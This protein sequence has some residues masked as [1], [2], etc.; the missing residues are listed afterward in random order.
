MSE[1]EI[2]Y[3][4]P[5]GKKNHYRAGMSKNGKAFI[6]KDRV[7][8]DYETLFKDSCRIYK[9]RNIKVP[10][11]LYLAIF[12]DNKR[13]DIDNVVTSVLDNLQAV[14]AI[15][16]DN[17]CKKIV[18]EKRPAKGIPRVQFAIEAEYKQAELF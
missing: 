14:R 11:I 3:G 6:Y 4:I 18:A 7:L 17:L 10:F 8:T 13:L 15:S 9:D 5:I 1:S 2:I 16:N 12:T